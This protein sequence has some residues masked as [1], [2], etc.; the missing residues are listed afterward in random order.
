MAP[1]SNIQ[2][3]NK[4]N[5]ERSNNFLG[6]NSNV[7]NVIN[8]H[9]KEYLLGLLFAISVAITLSLYFS[10]RPHDTSQ[11]HEVRPLHSSGA[12]QTNMKVIQP[13]LVIYISIP[14]ISTGCK[15]YMV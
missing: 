14:I 6:N 11:N 7:T 15:P 9:N 5:G 10:L 13:G 12:T 8:K 3:H 1:R 4:E 2:I